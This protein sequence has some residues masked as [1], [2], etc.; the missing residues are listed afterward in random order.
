M[1]WCRLSRISPGSSSRREYDLAAPQGVRGSDNSMMRQIYA[2]EPSISL[3]DGLE[4][5]Y[6]WIYDNVRKNVSI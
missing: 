1:S 3:R 4:K 6:A 5:T 2:R